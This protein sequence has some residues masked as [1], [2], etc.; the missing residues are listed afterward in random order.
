MSPKI[1]TITREIH[2]QE[3]EV[4]K[5]VNISRSSLISWKQYNGVFYNH[6]STYK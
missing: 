2:G 1:S 6:I 3:R 4:T 5:S